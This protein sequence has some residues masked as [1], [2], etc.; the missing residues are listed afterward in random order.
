MKLFDD[1]IL[2]DVFDTVATEIF[3]REISDIISVVCDNLGLA[4]TDFFLDKISIRDY[5]T[6]IPS[7][8]WLL[9]GQRP[10]EVTGYFV[11]DTDSIDGTKLIA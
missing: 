1:T 11:I 3:T 4:S 8:R 2:N 6:Q 7:C 9:T 10:S 5:P